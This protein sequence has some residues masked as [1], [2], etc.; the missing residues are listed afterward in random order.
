[1]IFID[2]CNLDGNGFTNRT[3]MSVQIVRS[4]PIIP[5]DALQI[6]RRDMSRL[7][8]GVNM[9]YLGHLGEYN[10]AILLKNSNDDTLITVARGQIYKYKP[11]R[12][13]LGSTM[14]TSKIVPI[15]SES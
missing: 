6:G 10:T 1:M 14:V 15:N 7:M 8:P 9:K 11:A 12:S 13:R 3:C 4:K 5:K 2:I